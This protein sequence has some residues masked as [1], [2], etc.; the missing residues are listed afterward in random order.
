MNAYELADNL[1]K[2]ASFN[3]APLL[4]TKSANMLSEQADQI[5]DLK[6]TIKFLEEE[7]KALRGQVN[8]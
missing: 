5:A 7:C 3:S 8:T 6:T 1:N 4:F 2:Y